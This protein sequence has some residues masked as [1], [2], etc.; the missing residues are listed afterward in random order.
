MVGWGEGEGWFVERKGD[1][2]CR[3]V[4]VKDGSFWVGGVSDGGMGWWNY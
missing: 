3:V 1:S 4:G 2:G